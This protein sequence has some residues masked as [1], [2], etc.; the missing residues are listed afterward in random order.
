[1]AAVP[2]TIVVA[3]LLAVSV[4][5]ILGYVYVSVKTLSPRQSY[6]ETKKYAIIGGVLIFSSCLGVSG[7]ALLRQQVLHLAP[8]FLVLSLLAGVLALETILS[9][10]QLANFWRKRA[11]RKDQ[12]GYVQGQPIIKRKAMTVR[13]KTWYVIG[14]ALN[15]VG[16]FLPWVRSG[17]F[18]SVWTP[19][20]S[21]YWM[22]AVRLYPSVIDNGGFLIVTLSVAIICLAFYV[23]SLPEQSTIRVILGVVLVLASSFQIAR[24]LVSRIMANGEIGAP[25]PQIGLVMALL[26]SLLLLSA[27]WLQHRN[28]I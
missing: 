20:I 21:I 9:P 19:G 1:V 24:W 6:E 25:T 10:A 26:G 18:L 4:A 3:I 27:A 22:P 13:S 16:S 14:A 11:R 28:A 17:D 23:S 15:I 5:G 12:A 2:L 7:V 8:A